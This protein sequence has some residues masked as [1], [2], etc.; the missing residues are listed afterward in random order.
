M[1]KK[2]I[3]IVSIVVVIVVIAIGVGIGIARADC[4][5][6]TAKN[7]GYTTEAVAMSR[8]VDQNNRVKVTVD[9]MVERHGMVPELTATGVMSVRQMVMAEVLAMGEMVS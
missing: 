6:V 3:V 7:V 2:S 9:N 8:V 5:S 4:G 1:N